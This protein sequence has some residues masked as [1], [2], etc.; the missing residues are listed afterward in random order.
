[1]VHIVSLYGKGNIYTTR[2]K[3]I[4]LSG[5]LSG[6]KMGPSDSTH[7][8]QGRANGKELSSSASCM[9]IAL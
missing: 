7:Q 3:N 6:H 4:N 5:L 2:E 1:M 8:P 9:I